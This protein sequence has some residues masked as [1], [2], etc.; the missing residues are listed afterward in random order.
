MLALLPGSWSERVFATLAIPFFTDER[1]SAETGLPAD[2]GGELPERQ[3]EQISEF[4]I[5]LQYVLWNCLSD[6]LSRS[7][8]HSPSICSLPGTLPAP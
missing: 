6:V 2:A 8:K 1:P 3:E 7:L 5:L 4:F